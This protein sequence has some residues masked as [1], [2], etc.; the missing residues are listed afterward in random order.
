VV[1]RASLQACRGTASWSVPMGAGDMNLRSRAGENGPSHG[2]RLRY[3]PVDRR[4]SPSHPRQA[5]RRAVHVTF[6]RQTRSNSLDAG[7]HSPKDDC[8]HSYGGRHDNVP[9]TEADGGL[10][11]IGHRGRGAMQSCRAWD[12]AV[13]ISLEWSPGRVRRAK[14]SR[15]APEMGILPQRSVRGPQA[16][17][18]MGTEMAADVRNGSRVDGSHVIGTI[19][20][21]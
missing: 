7:P 21:W 18:K 12:L 4:E 2:L 10:Y 13:L 16:P 1:C 17:R 8:S 5:R 15:N 19:H 20:E 14:W 6:A 9:G 11:A 3:R